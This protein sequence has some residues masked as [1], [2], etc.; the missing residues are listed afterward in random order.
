MHFYF[1]IFRLQIQGVEE[2][3]F[4]CIKGNLF[5]L[6]LDNNSIIANIVGAHSVRPTIFLHCLVHIPLFVYIL[7]HF[8]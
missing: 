7:P 6:L 1:N 4:V 8:L 5:V 3:L 2:K